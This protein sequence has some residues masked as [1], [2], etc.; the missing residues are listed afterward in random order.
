VIGYISLMQ[1]G[2]AGPIN[3]EQQ[4]TLGQ[5]KIASEQLLGLIGDLLELTTLKRGGLEV[6]VSGFDP[7]EPLQMAMANTPGRPQ[8]VQL[9]VIESPRIESGDGEHAP[10]ARVMW[11][12][13][14]KIAKIL[15]SLLSNAYKFTHEGE[16]RVELEV[17][18]DRVIFSVQDT[19]IGIP[20]E[21]QRFVFDEF[22]QVDGSITRRY[23]G[24]GL[25]L[26]LARRL[27]RLLG[28]DIVLVSTPS[29]GSTFRVEIPL[30]YEPNEEPTAD[31][32]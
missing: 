22:R 18:E 9:R 12:D 25:G 30:A 28:G 6:I 27:A 7:R 14:K 15:A 13:R 26:A 16:V 32:H 31:P 11:S 29:V 23:G 17:L 3:D 19:G 20:P 2:L 4:K 10:P 1:E 8:S 21:A 24:S 5:V